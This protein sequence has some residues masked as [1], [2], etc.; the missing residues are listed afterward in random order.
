MKKDS[1]A[2]INHLLI[3]EKGTALGPQNKYFFSVD[4][5]ANKPEIKRAVQEI[6]KVKVVDVNT[7]NVRGKKRRVR[8]KQGKTS[9]WKKAVVTLA[10][11]QSIEIA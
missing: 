8:F 7:M 5:R 11:G 10:E 2:V 1:Y 6:Y 3:T 4:R 9:N